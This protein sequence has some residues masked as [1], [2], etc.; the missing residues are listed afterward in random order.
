MLALSQFC[1]GNAYHRVKSSD[2][3]DEND[4]TNDFVGDVAEDQSVHEVDNQTMCIETSLKV[5][6]FICVTAAIGSYITLVCCLA[7]DNL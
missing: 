1:R 7:L 2:S 5:T 6:I 3:D 4:T